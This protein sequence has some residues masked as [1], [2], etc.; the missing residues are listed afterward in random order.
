M[1]ELMKQL[2][3]CLLKTGTRDVPLDPKYQPIIEAFLVGDVRILAWECLH[4]LYHHLEAT[5]ISH[6]NFGATS[7]PF[8]KRGDT[9]LWV[10][11]DGGYVDGEWSP[12]DLVKGYGKSKEEAIIQATIKVL[13]EEVPDAK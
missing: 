6:M 2:Q 3:D 11:S 7:Y 13:K 9:D 8:V 1:D 4:W 12:K 5:E 10:L